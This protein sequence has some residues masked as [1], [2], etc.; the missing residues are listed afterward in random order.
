MKEDPLGT[1]NV[2][3][4]TGNG[5]GGDDP[6][7]LDMDLE[8]DLVQQQTILYERVEIVGSPIVE[9]LK[10]EG[11]QNKDTVR[12]ATLNNSTSNNNVL[13]ESRILAYLASSFLLPYRESKRKLMELMQ[14]WS[15]WQAKHQLS[16]VIR[17][18]ESEDVPLEDGEETY[19]PALHVGSKKSSVVV[20][21]WT[22]K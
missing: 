20:C 10:G 1:E 18:L 16:S 15:Q 21:M 3:V 8:D 4:F 7:V 13:D 11:E 12:A 2:E 6:N 5:E 19:F 17:L 9:Q 22:K 14:Q